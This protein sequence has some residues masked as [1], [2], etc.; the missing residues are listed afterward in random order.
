MEYHSPQMS[1]L[2]A[3]SDIGRNL[4]GAIGTFS[5]GQA[6]HCMKKGICKEQSHEKI[7]IETISQFS[8]A[9][10]ITDRIPAWDGH[11]GLCGDYLGI[12]P[13]RNRVQRD[14]ADGMHL[15]ADDLFPLS[16]GK[17]GGPVE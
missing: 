1:W 11:D 13:E 12:Q 6:L 9:M 4:H 10:G 17:H 15:S 3:R 16:G 8:F 2:R 5:S 14:P 7:F